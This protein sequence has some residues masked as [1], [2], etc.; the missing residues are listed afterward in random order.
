VEDPRAGDIGD[1]CTAAA[2]VRR[3]TD[4]CRWVRFVGSIVERSMYVSIKGSVKQIFDNALKPAALAALSD[5]IQDAVD[6][7][8][9]FN[10]KKTEK[11]AIVLTATA[12]VDAD[13]NAK[14]TQIKATITIDGVLTG[15]APQAFKASGNGKMN[16]LNAKKLERDVSDLIESIVTDLMKSKVMPQM[17]KMKP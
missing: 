13:D 6:A 2:A 17:L 8:K 7:D 1:R 16:G 14:P 3:L 10:T 15:T 9:N 4:R 5:G 11:I 12:S